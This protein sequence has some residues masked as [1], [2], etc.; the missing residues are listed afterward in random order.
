MLKLV[1]L[2]FFLSF[3]LFSQSKFAYQITALFPESHFIGYEY[4]QP[5]YI[6]YVYPPKKSIG[7]ISNYVFEIKVYIKLNGDN[8]IWESPILL[9]YSSQVTPP[10]SLVLNS[11]CETLDSHLLYPYT[12]VFKTNYST[13]LNI[14]LSAVDPV[15]NQSDNLGVVKFSGNSIYV[16]IAPYKH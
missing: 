14:S 11:E 6:Y 2:C 12:F 15:H 4:S 9:K 5:N 8:F 1:I 10:D 3:N 13:W 16:D 7:F